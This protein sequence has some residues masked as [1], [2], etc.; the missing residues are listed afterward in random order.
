MSQVQSIPSLTMGNNPYLVFPHANT[1]FNTYLSTIEIS[2]GNLY[3]LGYGIPS[4][5]WLKVHKAKH[6]RNSSDPFDK[7]NTQHLP[8]KPADIFPPIL[9]ITSDTP[10]YERVMYSSLVKQQAANVQAI[11]KARSFL[12]QLMGPY[13]ISEIHNS[14]IE[15]LPGG[16]NDLSFNELVDKFQMYSIM[17]KEARVAAE[18]A[19]QTQLHEA[20]QFPEHINKLKVLFK[21]FDDANQAKNEDSKIEILA[22][23]IEFLPNHLAAF[24]TWKIQLMEEEDRT[25]NN[26]ALYVKTQAPNH[27][28]TVGSAQY[29]LVANSKA[30]STPVSTEQTSTPSEPS[31]IIHGTIHYFCFCH[32]AI[33]PGSGWG[34]AA[35]THKTSQCRVI[36]K[37]ITQR[38]PVVPVK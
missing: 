33:R 23:S 30:S 29:A 28:P 37:S 31:S 21:Q 17:N 38:H 12:L 26:A 6:L 35:S 7:K 34:T 11:A 20:T 36:K 14:I 25:F 1:E 2:N 24:N 3:N 27:A 32:E 16:I 15:E 9:P 18:L 22:K 5:N 13:V 19:L 10:E 8:I 4:A